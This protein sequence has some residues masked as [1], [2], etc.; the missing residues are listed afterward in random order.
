MW[1]FRSEVIAVSQVEAACD[2][3]SVCT[4]SA[5]CTELRNETRGQAVSGLEA[6]SVFI[7]SH[8]ETACTG[9]AG[10]W[11]EL[12][13]CAEIIMRS[14]ASELLPEWCFEW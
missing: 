9:S 6:T 2:A 12:C 7:Y 3:F 8:S 1:C 13:S 5:S 11:Q 4:M 14:M 10:P